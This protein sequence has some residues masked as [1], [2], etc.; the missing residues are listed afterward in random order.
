[1]TGFETRR[2]LSVGMFT[3]STR[4]RGSVVCAGQLATALSKLGHDVHLYALDKGEGGFFTEVGCSFH[5]IPAG[6]APRDP[7]AL[8]RQRISEVQAYVMTS[9]LKHDVVHAQDCLVASGLIGA[10]AKGAL[11]TPIVRTLHHVEEHRTAYLEKCQRTSV[12][13]ADAVI[14]VSKASQREIAKA[15]G[16]RARLIHS[17]VEPSGK[18]SQSL[19]ESLGVTRPFLLSVGGIEP[20]KNSYNQ[21]RAFASL[22][23]AMPELTW[24]IAGGASVWEH[25]EYRAGFEDHKATLARNAVRV[26]DVVSQP[27]LDALYGSA[28][29]LLH[30]ATKEGWGLAVLEAMLRRIPVVVSEGAPFDEYL[31]ASSAFLSSPGDPESIADAIRAALNASPALLDN[32]WNKARDFDWHQSALEHEALYTS[33]ATHPKTPTHP[34]AE[35]QSCPR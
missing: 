2:P 19:L 24:V 10:R 25:D 5:A 21:L 18:F 1:V 13:Q 26:L 33:L 12:T 16:V 15:F 30:A 6:S 32:A 27:E 7:D 34:F 17:G 28:S 11:E 8:I 31:D 22:H 3:Y 20:R 4:P 23:E 35:N 29:V 9:L 14:A